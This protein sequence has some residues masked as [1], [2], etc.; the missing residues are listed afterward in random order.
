MKTDRGVTGYIHEI[1]GSFQGEGPYV[2]ERHVFVRFCRCGL[3]CRYC[4]TPDSRIDQQVAYIEDGPG[5]TSL[6]V[7][8]PLSVADVLKAVHA[9]EVFEGYNSAVSIT[10]G[11]P[12]EQPDFLAA[13]LV[14]LGGRF[15]I[16]LETNGTLP[17]EL[18][19][20]SRLVDVVSMDIKLPSVT[21]K[22]PLW[23]RHRAFIAECRGVEL[24]VKVVVGPDTTLEEIGI[25][26]E[27]AV[28]HSPSAVFVIQPLTS[29]DQLDDGVVKRLDMLYN[30]A[31]RRLKRVRVIPQVHKL[32]KV[33]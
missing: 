27:M 7:P 22:G 26:A 11:E 32:L 3:G 31:A 13:L 5:L 14:G 2:G 33:K 28:D 9:Q 10:G 21:G 19:M 17:D 25:A 16:L 12:L 18:S 29:G 30:E 1:F 8:N 4:D 15:R 6:V 23:D 24:V 20:V